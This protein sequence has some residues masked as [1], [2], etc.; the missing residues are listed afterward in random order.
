MLIG[1]V[2]KAGSGK[3]TAANHL[4]TKYRFQ[5][6]AYATPIKKQLCSMLHIPLG[7]YNNLK[8]GTW[9]S[10][11]CGYNFSGRNLL[12]GVGMMMRDHDDTQFVKYVDNLLNPLVDTVISDVRFENEVEHIRSRNGIIINIS[13]NGLDK[14]DSI[15]EK[16]ADNTYDY[17]LDNNGT[18]DDLNK[19]INEL[20]K[21]LSDNN[22]KTNFEQSGV[23]IET[24]RKFDHNVIFD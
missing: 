20:L 14:S 1:I 23:H 19:Q 17:T 15:T 12:V 2:G 9:K 22:Q 13:R 7:E 10:D 18:I 8:R 24:H 4:C 3:D 16:L 11:D 5:R 21:Q 6:L